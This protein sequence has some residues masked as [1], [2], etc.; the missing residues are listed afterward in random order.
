MKFR[1]INKKE[2]IANIDKTEEFVHFTFRPSM[3]DVISLLNRAPD[4]DIIQM[5]PSYIKS[6]SKGIDYLFEMKN[7]FLSD[8]DVWGHRSDISELIEVPTS[9]MKDMYNEGK[10]P[11]Q[12]SEQI[13]QSEVVVNYVL[14]H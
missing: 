14:S 1:I 7:V 11:E 6:L 8:G 12:I 2:D 3:P 4:I 13:N 9:L 10:T 5:P